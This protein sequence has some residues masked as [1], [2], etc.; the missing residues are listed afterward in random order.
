MQLGFAMLECGMCRQN[1]VAT[2]SKNILDV[3]FAWFV[4]YLWGFKL[5]YGVDVRPELTDVMSNFFHHLVFQATSPTIVS[6]DGGA[7]EPF[8]LCRPRDCRVGCT[9]LH[10]RA[11][12]VGWRVARSPRPAIPR[13]CRLGGRPPAGGVSA[14]VGV[15]VVGARA[16]GTTLHAND[17]ILHDVS[18]VLSGVLVLWV[19]WYAFNAGS[20]NALASADDVFAASNSAVTTTMAAASGAV[21]A[22]VLGIIRQV[23]GDMHS[24]DAVAIGNG[25]LAGLV[26]ITAGADCIRGDWSILVGFGGAVAYMLGAFMLERFKPMI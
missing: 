6:G 7:H 5:A 24:V 3:V 21:S 20:T 17:F 26:S 9:V 13:L 4:S 12:V 2:Y 25:I 23:V 1:N 11:V 14:L 19:G 8:R 16:G 22:M 15:W 18:S 10:R